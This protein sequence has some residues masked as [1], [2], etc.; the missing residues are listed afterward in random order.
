MCVRTGLS[1][2]AVFDTVLRF[3]CSSRP[4]VLARRT[5][6]PS[7]ISQPSKCDRREK[8]NRLWEG[9]GSKP[10]SMHMHG[11]THAHTHTQ[12]VSCDRYTFDSLRRQ[13]TNSAIKYSFLIGSGPTGLRSSCSL[14]PPL[15]LSLSLPPPPP[16][17]CWVRHL[18]RF[19][20]TR[21]GNLELPKVLSFKPREGK[22]IRMACLTSAKIYAEF[23][24]SRFTTPPPPEIK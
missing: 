21:A 2:I 24:H 6:P 8:K 4:F 19:R 18:Q 12:H 17:R 20:L 16:Q 14:S 5:R 9:E 11:R 1:R 22:N 3:S 15:S 23:L 7:N 10:T 13:V